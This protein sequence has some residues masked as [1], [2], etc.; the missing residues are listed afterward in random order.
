MKYLIVLLVLTTAAM[1]SITLQYDE[2]E[3]GESPGPGF[4][5]GRGAAVWYDLDSLG[6]S[7]FSID[8]VEIAFHDYIFW[9][10]PGFFWIELWEDTGNHYQPDS[11]LWESEMMWAVE[12][13][14]TPPDVV[15]FMKRFS[16]EYA[17]PLSGHVWVV[18]T[19]QCST[20]IPSIVGQ[21]TGY[22][23][24]RS[25]HSPSLWETTSHDLVIRL[26]GE[27]AS[28]LEQNTWAAIKA[29]F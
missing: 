13:G 10:C 20:D 19:T 16:V 2:F 18:I 25:L 6:Y 28:V 22:N 7:N 14:E 27:D 8:S 17:E 21:Q 3:L 4:G 24:A 1:S 23:H 9:H 5:N 15:P 26:I 11:M 29:N 12:P